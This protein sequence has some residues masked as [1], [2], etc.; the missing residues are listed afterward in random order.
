[1]NLKDGLDSANSDMGSIW[2][3]AI[4]KVAIPHLVH[5]DDRNAMARSLEGRMPF[6][7]HRLASLMSNVA[8]GGLYDQGLQKTVLR[9]SLQEVIPPLVLNRRDKIGFFTPIHDLIRARVSQIEKQILS[10]ESQLL[11]D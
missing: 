9:K 1:M 5:Y 6:L 11:F 4:E 10:S 2:L 7:D 8:F 3:E